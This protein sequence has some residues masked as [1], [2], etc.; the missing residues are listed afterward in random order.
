MVTWIRA[1]PAIQP[2]L[3]RSTFPAYFFSTCEMSDQSPPSR[4]RVQFESALREYQ[5]QTK[6]S[7]ASHPLAE[8]LRSCDSVESVTTVLQ[9]QARASSE[10]RDRDGRI[11]K[12]L[13]PIVSVLYAIS[14]SIALDEA[15]GL[16]CR[17]TRLGTPRP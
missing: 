9:D 3:P 14:A 15:I 2:L 8:Q 5:K 7:L 11:M 1:V 4:F 6:T 10:L 16:V 13:G 17:D 12:S